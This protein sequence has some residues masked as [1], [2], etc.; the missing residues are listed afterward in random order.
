MGWLF[1]FFGGGLGSVARF[2]ISKIIYN[3]FEN[4]FPIATLIVNALSCIILGAF[5][6]MLP[7]KISQNS[8]LYFLFI[9]GFCGGFSTFSTFSYETIQLIKYGFLLYAILNIIFNVALCLFII[10]LFTLKAKYD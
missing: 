10:Y 8:T 3:N 2:F 1:V 5:L 7:S 4:N 6:F 9:T